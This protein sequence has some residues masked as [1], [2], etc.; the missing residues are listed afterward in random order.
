MFRGHHV[1]GKHE[2]RGRDERRGPG[3][4]QG[5][6]QEK[7]GH[8]AEKQVEE[9]TAVQRAD[10]P[11]R[12]DGVDQGFETVLQMV[13]GAAGLEGHAAEDVGVPERRLVILFFEILRETIERYVLA[14]EIGP[15][16]CLSFDDVAAVHEDG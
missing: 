7:H 9:E 8:R 12:Q 15:D 2:G 6:R 16:I 10:E 11:V 14:D 3:E 1:G 4:R 13:I 5:T